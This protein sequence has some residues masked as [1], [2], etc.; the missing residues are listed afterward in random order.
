MKECV[1]ITCSFYPKSS[2][3]MFT[4]I[5]NN[6]ILVVSVKKCIEF[7]DYISDA[8]VIYEDGAIL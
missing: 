6:K 3:T 7:S 4:K 8:G 1:A 5:F 2:C